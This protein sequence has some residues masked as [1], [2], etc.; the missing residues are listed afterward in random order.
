MLNL[1]VTK[2]PE[3]FPPAVFLKYYNLL[4]KS[5]QERNCRLRNWTDRAANLMGKILLLKGLKELGFT[6][7]ILKKVQ[8]DPNQRP[9]I[10]GDVDFNISHSGAYV[11]C[12]IGRSIR[13]GIDIEEIKNVDLS[14]YNNIMNKEQWKHV[15]QAPVPV[16]EFYRYW[17]IKES[18]V[19]ADSRGLFI[20]MK[21]ITIT[22]NQVGINGVLWHF[23][24]FNIDDQ[25]CLSLTTDKALSIS[26]EESQPLF[27]DCLKIF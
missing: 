23:K 5:M 27:F 2:I 20:P 26:Q 21:D 17:T 22:G 18:G 14:E 7:V 4:P 15:L 9:F 25:Y 3:V 16:R 12:A 8:L 1:L 10:P 6:K 13:V 19:K 24:E 11:V